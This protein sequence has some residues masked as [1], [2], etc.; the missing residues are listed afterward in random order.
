MST[1]LKSFGY[2]Q[3]R[4]KVPLMRPEEEQAFIELASEANVRFLENEEFSGRESMMIPVSKPGVTETVVRKLKGMIELTGFD[5]KVC[6]RNGSWVL[7][8]T[9]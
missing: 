5:A 1:L 6:R 2:Q 9:S 7:S 8:V 4:F 3:N